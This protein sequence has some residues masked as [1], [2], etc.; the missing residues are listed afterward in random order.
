MGIQRD[1]QVV[2]VPPRRIPLR[3]RGLECDIGGGQLPNRAMR[4][5]EREVPVQQLSIDSVR[6]C[7]LQSWRRADD[8]LDDELL[9]GWSV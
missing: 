5:G 1:S 2:K 6:A 3:E 9:E 8:R 7:E 4:P